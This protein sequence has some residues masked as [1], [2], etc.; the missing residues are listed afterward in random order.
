M[1]ASVG[2][3]I[4]DCETPRGKRHTLSLRVLT[5]ST[6]GKI[7]VTGQEKS[8]QKVKVKIFIII[9]SETYRGIVLGTRQG[10]SWKST[11]GSWN[12]SDFV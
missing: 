12:K 4:G 7:Q 9:N 1:L 11:K 10:L 8:L 3:E 6:Q 5:P 2:D